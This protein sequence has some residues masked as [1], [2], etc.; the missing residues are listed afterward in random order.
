MTDARASRAGQ[1]GST[2]F[3]GT[4]WTVK[5]GGSDVWSAPDQF[6]Y[7]YQSVSGDATLVAKV[8]SVQNTS[9]WA[10]AG[11]MFRD[12]TAAGAPYVAVLQNP[13]NLLEM[14]WRDAAGV[15]SNWNGAQV[16]DTTN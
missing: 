15:D 16:G 9:A 3:D 11:V 1:S 12:G 13:N 2:A 6:Q 5:G 7:A 14:Q 10:K 4:T 8:T